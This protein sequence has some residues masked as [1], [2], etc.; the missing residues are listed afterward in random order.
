MTLIETEPAPALQLADGFNSTLP[1]EARPKGEWRIN[2]KRD[3]IFKG[4][5][6]L[7]KLERMGLISTE[8]SSVGLDPSDR[9]GDDWKGKTAST[10]LS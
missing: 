10:S 4:R 9:V 6:L 8:Q 5:Q 2:I 3:G 1:E 7:S